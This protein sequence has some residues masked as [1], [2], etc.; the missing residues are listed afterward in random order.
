MVPPA[1]MRSATRPPE[2][3]APVLVQE[4]DDAEIFVGQILSEPRQF[5]AVSFA[6]REPERPP[7]PFLFLRVLRASSGVCHGAAFPSRCAN[8]FDFAHRSKD[9]KNSAAAASAITINALDP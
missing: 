3:L 8:R 1:K 6:E 5:C 2:I 9:Q 7:N 4:F